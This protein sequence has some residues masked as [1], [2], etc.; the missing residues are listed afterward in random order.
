MA[1]QRFDGPPAPEAVYARAT[2]EATLASLDRSLGYGMHVAGDLD[3]LWAT[4]YQAIARVPL[5]NLAD[6]DVARVL[7]S[8]MHL[9]LT[10]PHAIARLTERNTVDTLPSRLV[11]AVGRAAR[12][13]KQRLPQLSEQAR[14]S[15]RAVGALPTGL[16]ADPAEVADLRAVIAEALASVDATVAEENV[17]GWREPASSLSRRPSADELRAITAPSPAE[18]PVRSPYSGGD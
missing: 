2:A 13:V 5:K 15:L 6:D 14:A 4:W 16:D 1:E 9:P 8:A 10:L 3:P 7:D 18:R 11:S 17:W 12:R